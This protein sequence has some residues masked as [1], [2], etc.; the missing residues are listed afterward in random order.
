LNSDLVFVTYIMM[1]IDTVR[2][3][4]RPWRNEDGDLFA[5]LGR[6]AL[7]DRGGDPVSDE[8]WNE[9]GT[10]TNGPSPT[11]CSTSP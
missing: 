5:A 6:A 8:V 7:A 11:S 3:R 4:L 2:T 10:T 9:P 1:V